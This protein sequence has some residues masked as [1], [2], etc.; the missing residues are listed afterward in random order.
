MILLRNLAEKKRR[1]D[2]WMWGSLVGSQGIVYFF[3]KRE[4]EE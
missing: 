4:R 3:S 2:K 1:V